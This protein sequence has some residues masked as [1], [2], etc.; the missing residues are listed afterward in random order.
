MAPCVGAEKDHRLGTRKQ[1]TKTR[2]GTA[3]LMANPVG[4]SAMAMLAHSGLPKALY[5]SPPP[6]GRTQGQRDDCPRTSEEWQGGRDGKSQERDLLER[7]IDLQI[8]TTEAL[9]KMLSEGPDL[10]VS[11]SGY[12][13]RKHSTSTVFGGTSGG[14]VGWSGSQEA[15]IPSCGVWP[16][17]FFGD[18][19]QWLGSTCSA[20]WSSVPEPNDEP[21]RGHLPPLSGSSFGSSNRHVYHGS[22][23]SRD[24]ARELLANLE[25]MLSEKRQCSVVATLKLGGAREQRG[26]GK[27]W[28]EKQSPPR[29]KEENQQPKGLFLFPVLQAR[30]PGD[31]PSD[32]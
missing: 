24:L 9:S 26:A 10:L 16:L 23:R 22:C 3:D 17:T 11:S 6:S 30:F 28:E 29:A 5:R 19:L 25:R 18:L 14:T 31:V 12:I 21:L 20:V 7:L 27:T 13:Q 32:S 8:S 15:G 4:R 1:V 2:I